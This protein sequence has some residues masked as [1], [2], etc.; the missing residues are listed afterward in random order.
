MILR[1]EPRP[2]ESIDR[3]N[4]ISRSKSLRLRNWTEVGALRGQNP[5]GPS[6]V[7][8]RWRTWNFQLNELRP[9]WFITDR[10][11]K[12]SGV[13]VCQQRD[14]SRSGDV[15]GVSCNRAPIDES[16]TTLLI[17][18]V[19]TDPDAV[20]IGLVWNLKRCR[21]TKLELQFKSL[22]VDPRRFVR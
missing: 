22:A 16:K 9:A 20:T 11:K 15:F 14:V 21:R 3:A 7:L 2:V 10:G 18:S 17:V 13:A 5:F 4:A 6:F 12:R 8:L 19:K 1:F